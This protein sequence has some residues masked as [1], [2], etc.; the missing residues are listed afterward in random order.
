LEGAKLGRYRMNQPSTTIR[1]FSLRRTPRLIFYA[2][3]GSD[4]GAISPSG[5]LAP[6]S[7]L[8]TLV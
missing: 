1:H 6:I 5:F 8:T 2:H 7:F 3:L 4:F